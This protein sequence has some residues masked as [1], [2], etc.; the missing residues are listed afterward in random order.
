MC[1]LEIMFIYLKYYKNSVKRVT[2][3]KLIAFEYFVF[4]I[5]LLCRNEDLPSSEI[6]TYSVKTIFIAKTLPLFVLRRRY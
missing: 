3:Y 1:L 2:V 4:P 6:Y 5:L